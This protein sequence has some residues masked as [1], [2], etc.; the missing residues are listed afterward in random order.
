V[1]GVGTFTGYG[2][3]PNPPEPTPVTFNLK[4][5]LP[6]YQVTNSSV[7]PELTSIAS[8]PATT[9][10]TETIVITV[11]F[12][13]ISDPSLTVGQQVED[14]PFYNISRMDAYNLVGYV[15]NSKS[16]S[17]FSS[18]KSVTVGVSDTESKSYS[19]SVGVSISYSV[20]VEAMGVTEKMKMSLTESFGYTQTSS[21][22]EMQSTTKSYDLDAD[23]YCAAAIWT[24]N[25]AYNV[26]RNDGTLVSNSLTF[27]QNVDSYVHSNYC[28]DGTSSTL[29]LSI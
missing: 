22:T 16:S 27:N 3:Y 20:G 12:Q 5:S 28:V 23:A 11:P 21:V 8:P 29:E 15:D 18:T 7:A 14:S 24:M 13:A 6:V 19:E 9:S 26:L 10:P 4:L 25:S 1:I 2:G 17:Q